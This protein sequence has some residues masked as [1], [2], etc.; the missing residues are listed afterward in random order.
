MP[1]IWLYSFKFLHLAKCFQE[2]SVWNIHTVKIQNRLIKIESMNNIILRI[3]RLLLLFGIPLVILFSCKKATLPGVTTTEVTRITQTSAYSGGQVISDGGAHISARGVCW[4]TTGDPRL[5]DNK[6]VDSIGLGLFI[7]HLTGLVPNTLYY[8]RAYVTNSEGTGYGDI[9]TFTTDT[10]ALATLTTSGLKSV[11]DETAQGGGIIT[12]D[13]GSP[14]TERGVCW[15]TT[16]SPTIEDIHTSDGTGAG[17]YISS[18]TGLSLNTTY[19]VRAYATNSLGTS[20][21]LQV[22]FVQ[23]EPILDADGNA[24]SV[25]TIGTQVWFGENLRTSKFRDGSQ[26]PY[27]SD[28]TSWANTVTPAYCWY[29]NDNKYKETYGGLYNWYAVSTGRLCPTG[30]HVPSA[31]EY[32]V[33]IDYLGGMSI[34]GGKLKEAGTEHWVEPNTGATNGSG[35]TALPGGGRY[36]IYSEGGVFTDMGYFAYFWSST[37]STSQSNAVSF[38]MAYT[39]GIVNKG[40]YSRRDGGSV[41][42]INDNK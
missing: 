7:S 20:Y 38:D 6:T 36:N 25:I 18:L 16:G 31:D 3:D 23:R 1:G 5:K 8:V 29:S 4:N 33:L 27:V 22:E 42:C 30:W 37:P 26:I 28:G 11:T 40:E 35:F 39:V 21:G 17:T 10:E 9:V 14:I 13:G 19:Y 15:N 34:A 41:R 32:A 2:N 24:Y 12:N